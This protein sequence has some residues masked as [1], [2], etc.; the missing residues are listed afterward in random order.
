MPHL[1]VEKMSGFHLRG[2][3]GNF[4]LYTRRYKNDHRKG[5]GFT[6]VLKF[7]NGSFLGKI[8]RFEWVHSSGSL[9]QGTKGSERLEGQ[10]D[11]IFSSD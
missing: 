3:Q 5:K 9:G 1:D 11:C 8:E 6:K 10:R 2:L 4:P 7:W